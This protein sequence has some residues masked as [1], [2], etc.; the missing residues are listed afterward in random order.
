[1][2]VSRILVAFWCALF[3]PVAARLY[4]QNADCTERTFIVNVA[5]HGMLPTDLSKDNFQINYRGQALTPRNIYYTEGPRR[6]MVLLDVS[7]SMKSPQ[8]S[9]AKWKIARMAAWDLVTALPPGTKV[10]LIT[11]SATNQTQVPLS[12]TREPILDWLN[13]EAVDASQLKGRTALYDA[14]ES[15]L[16]QLKPVE[17]GDAIYVVSDGG[18]NASKTANR[19]R[20]RK[21]LLES[22]VRAFTLVVP[23]EFTS[24]EEINGGH[25][26]A[27]LSNDSGG[28]VDALEPGLGVVD[29]SI[30]RQIKLHSVHLSLQISAFYS[31]T[32]E[33]PENPQKGKRWDVTVLESGKRRKDISLGYPHEV[34]PCEV[35][36]AQ[37]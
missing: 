21:A 1:M 28:F 20:V 29:E 33:L 19:S 25:E 8:G 34:P 17:P 37:K 10:G 2:R 35:R 30:K 36:T 3:V 26:M 27:S 7:G 18:E 23:G 22:G 15:A 12:I 9:T 16:A 24:V 14:I 4:G 11:F 6:V 32:V 13:H 31:L 5:D